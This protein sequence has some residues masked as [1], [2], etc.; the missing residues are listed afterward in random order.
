MSRDKGAQGFKGFISFEGIEGCGKTTQV[1]LL[2]NYLRSKN[3]R[4]LIT[5]EPG[6]TKIG[7]KIRTL[8]L[9]PEN[10]MDPLTELLLYN[11]SRAQHVREVIYPA[12]IQNTVVITDRFVDSTVSYQGYAR[13][14][15]VAIIRAL[16]EIV[17]PDLKPFVTFLLDLEVE[18]GLKRNRGAQ[19]IDRLELETIEFHNQVRNGYLQ[20]ASEEPDRIKVIDASGSIEEVSKKIIEVLETVWP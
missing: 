7:R 2:G 13:G 12:L 18:D 17:V 20:I 5:E 4:V 11:S 1:K 19:K 14:I 15:E 3:Q 6:G 10:H 9:S 8:L 16:N